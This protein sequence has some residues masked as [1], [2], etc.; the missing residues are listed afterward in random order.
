M[1]CNCKIDGQKP[2]RTVDNTIQSALDKFHSTCKFN[3][4][5]KMSDLG[6]NDKQLSV[7]LYTLEGQFKANFGCPIDIQRYKK[8]SIV[9][10]KTIINQAEIL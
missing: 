10:I 4:L 2:G 3:N 6:L 1:N 5:T 9:E 8:L 7:L